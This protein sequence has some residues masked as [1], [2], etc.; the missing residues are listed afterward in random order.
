M[1][2][3]GFGGAMVIAPVPPA[4]G[5][6]SCYKRAQEIVRKHHPALKHEFLIELQAT[7]GGIPSQRV[8]LKVPAVLSNPSGVAGEWD[9]NWPGG[10][11]ETDW[12]FGQQ[13]GAQ[14]A[15]ECPDR[16]DV[17]D[18]KAKLMADATKLAR[19]YELLI[20]KKWIERLRSILASKMGEKLGADLREATGLPAVPE[21]SKELVTGG[22]V[23][24]NAISELG[25]WMEKKLI[26]STLSDLRKGNLESL[27]SSVSEEALGKGMCDNLFSKAE[28]WRGAY[29]LINED[30]T[31]KALTPYGLKG[32]HYHR[33]QIC[34]TGEAYLQIGDTLSSGDQF[35]ELGNKIG[36]TYIAQKLGKK[37][38]LLV[39]AAY[40]GATAG[41]AIADLYAIVQIEQE[42]DALS[43]L[44][45][46][47][48]SWTSP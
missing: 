18:K 12:R 22:K 2:V 48:R 8:A 40:Y 25:G 14:P 36:G 20:M 34:N 9:G 28:H 23:M 5:L 41:W 27:I 37:W 29:Q 24:E 6:P 13:L 19:A 15:P 7:V 21:V 3:A 30:L 35:G 26:G 43:K 10:T 42:L 16:L 31:R 46:D 38:S 17:S 44:L 11:P 33:F 1:P 32:V 4:V 39:Q 47:P 45:D